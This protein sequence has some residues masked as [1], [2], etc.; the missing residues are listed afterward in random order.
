MEGKD[1]YHVTL[2]TQGFDDYWA[3]YGNILSIVT[4]MSQSSKWIEEIREDIPT[5]S[6]V[7]RD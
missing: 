5:F 3:L 1:I 7:S 6:I 2:M 4:Y